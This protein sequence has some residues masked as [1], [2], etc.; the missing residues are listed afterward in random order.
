L[1]DSMAAFIHEHNHQQGG[2]LCTFLYK[3]AKEVLCADSVS[4]AA[5]YSVRSS[6]AK[7][8]VHR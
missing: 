5:S 4:T 7:Y 2:L 8:R 1:K 3:E 6:S